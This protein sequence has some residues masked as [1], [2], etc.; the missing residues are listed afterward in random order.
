M[1][2]SFYIYDLLHGS[3]SLETALKL[4]ENLINLMKSG[5]FN[6]RKWNSNYPELS[7]DPQKQDQ[8]NYNFKLTESTKTL[9]LH[10]NP[11]QDK[12]IFQSNINNKKTEDTKRS[13]LSD[14]SK[15]F[16]PGVADTTFHQNEATF[17]TSME[18]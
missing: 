2:H 18:N 12:I 4:Q 11:N 6:L 13:L 8:G 10:W 17:S 15:L 9:G 14:I 16:D 7:Q 5:G 1:E 3:H